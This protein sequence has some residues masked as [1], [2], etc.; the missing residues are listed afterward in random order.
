MARDK[1]KADSMLLTLSE[2]TDA[3]VD[4]RDVAVWENHLEWIYV[5]VIWMYSISAYCTFNDGPERYRMYILIRVE[6]FII[7]TFMFV[8][9]ITSSYYIIWTISHSRFA[10]TSFCWLSI[11]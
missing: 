5:L 2:Q 7:D 8:V 4:L 10:T 9:I 1:P 3:E 11:T 6:Q